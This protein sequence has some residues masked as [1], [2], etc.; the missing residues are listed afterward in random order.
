MTLGPQW[1]NLPGYG[2]FMRDG[3]GYG[4]SLYHGSARDIPGRV[5][6]ASQ[7][8]HKRVNFEGL[9]D[10]DAAYATENEDTAWE[11]GAHAVLGRPHSGVPGRLRVHEVEPHPDMEVG[12][13]HPDHPDFDIHRENL[14]EWKA[15]HFDVKRTIDIKPGQQGTFPLNWNQFRKHPTQE[16]R[17]GDPINHPDDDQIAEGHEGGQMYRE[18]LE[19][20]WGDPKDVVTRE[21][22]RKMRNRS[23]LLGQGELW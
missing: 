21:A 15:P 19:K 14:S 4:D 6:P 7:T 3:P 13:F 1:Q 5:L 17:W 11:Y 16:P 10:K 20:F 12:Q 22:E 23:V 18:S 8:R 9:S 2:D